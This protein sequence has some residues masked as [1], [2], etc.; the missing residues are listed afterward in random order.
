M[1]GTYFAGPLGAGTG[2]GFLLE[3]AF[4][5]LVP[6]ASIEIPFL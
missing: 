6:V 5:V 4:T 3:A 1:R 2:F